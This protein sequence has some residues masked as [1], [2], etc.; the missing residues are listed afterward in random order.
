[1]YRIILYNTFDEVKT[2]EFP[3][4]D[5]GFSPKEKE[6]EDVWRIILYIAYLA[7][8]DIGSP[9]NTYQNAIVHREHDYNKVNKAGEF[10]FM[11]GHIK[12]KIE[13]IDFA[14]L[15]K[16]CIRYDFRDIVKLWAV[17]RVP[18]AVISDPDLLIKTALGM[19]VDF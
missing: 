10:Y 7:N 1:M 3:L 18:T 4:A 17:G 13:F 5:I 2:Y 16:N 19:G 6:H 8:N 15:Y 12:N 11:S 14:M 9:E